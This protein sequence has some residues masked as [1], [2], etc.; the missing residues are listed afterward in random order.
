MWQVVVKATGEQLYKHYDK[1]ECAWHLVDRLE[2]VDGPYKV[3]DLEI[4]QVKPSN[5][6]AGMAWTD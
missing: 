5:G 4:T 3:G 6:I 2:E 1:T